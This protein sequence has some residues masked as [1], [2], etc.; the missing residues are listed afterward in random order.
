[1]YVAGQQWP[2]RNPWSLSWSCRPPVEHSGSSYGGFG[3]SMVISCKLHI[4]YCGCTDAHH[5][6][7]LCIVSLRTPDSSFWPDACGS[8][9]PDFAQGHR[10]RS[11]EIDSERARDGGR[12]QSETSRSLAELTATSTSIWPYLFVTHFALSAAHALDLVALCVLLRFWVAWLSPACAACALVCLA[13]GEPST[14]SRCFVLCWS[15]E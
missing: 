10:G 4:L 15:V 3:V 11:E 12:K 1:M 9:T 14:T 7:L 5:H 2:R 13:G 8:A 6:C